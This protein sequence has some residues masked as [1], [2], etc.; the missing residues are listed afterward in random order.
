MVKPM[1]KCW[2]YGCRYEWWPETKEECRAASLPNAIEFVKLGSGEVVAFDYVFGE[3]F[4]EADYTAA[5]EERNNTILTQFS[6]D[7]SQILERIAKG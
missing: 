3:V 2:I 6:G 1:L 5:V 4:R 7:V